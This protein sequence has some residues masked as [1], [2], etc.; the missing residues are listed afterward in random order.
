MSRVM[1]IKDSYTSE[2][3][4]NYA[5][6]VSPL[7][8]DLIAKRDVYRFG[9]RS[10]W[11]DGGG[12]Q[13]VPF[14]H[15][16]FWY[17]GRRGTRVWA[18]SHN[19]TVY[20]F[21]ERPGQA[22]VVTGLPFQDEGR[23]LMNAFQGPFA[24]ICFYKGLPLYKKDEMAMY[25]THTKAP[26]NNESYNGFFSKS[27]HA[28]SLPPRPLLASTNQPSNILRPTSQHHRAPR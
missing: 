24:Y 16:A 19:N 27:I 4:E 12:T 11:V 3:F 7:E 23:T 15:I 1:E 20:Y 25:S 26:I 5:R 10:L 9:T 18:H 8:F 22:L 28:K 13:K 2:D 14:L 21:Y 6:K 17:H